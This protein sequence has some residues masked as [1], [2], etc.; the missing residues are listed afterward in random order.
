MGQASYPL[1]RGRQIWVAAVLL[2][3]VFV[4]SL[5]GAKLSA[6]FGRHWR[7]AR[8]GTVND[9]APT[10]KNPDLLIGYNLDYPGDWSDALPFLDL[11]HDARLWE[12]GGG[13]AGPLGKYAA[14]DLDE[15][16]WPRS[17]GGYA[18]LTAIVRTG[19]S[20]DF[21]GKVWVLS[22]KGE[23]SLSIQGGIDVLDRRPGRIRFRGEP[24]NVW[25]SIEADDPHKVG[26]YL[27]DI[28]IVR[29]DRQD[30]L[31]AGKLFN[32]DLLSFLAPYR[33][34]RFMDWMLS[35]DEEDDH[36][37]RWPER[38]KPVQVQWRQQ[39]IDPRRP[40]AG[41]TSPGYPVEI[42]IALANQLRAHPHFNLPYKFDDVYARSFATLVKGTLLPGLVAT[43]EYSN[44]LWNWGFPQATYARLEAAKLWPGEGTGWLQFMGARAST[45]CRIWKEVFGAEKQRLRCLIAPQTGWTDV[46]SA[47]LDCPRWVAMGHEPCY[48]SADAIGITGYFNGLLPKPENTPLI[49]QWLQQ[50]KASALDK[51]FRQLEWGDVENIK[52]GDGASTPERANSLVTTLS[53]FR[54]FR[55]IADE[56]GLGLYVYEGGTH[57]DHGPDP[58]LK[59]FLIDV[60]RDPRMTALYVKMFSGFASV[61][62]SVFNVWGGIGRASAWANADHLMDRSHPKYRAAV[63]FQASQRRSRESLS[64]PK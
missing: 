62:G 20:P 24:G 64:R 34:L 15:H 2:C 39:F 49:K 35:N 46:A 22:Y 36:A 10:P 27:R 7:L 61:N 42:M 45:M 23:G 48:K 14:L 28:T 11:M 21:V 9:S 52:D 3:L 8:A 41:L 56:R 4:L 63:E 19:D 44:E 32:P 54:T 53:L 29:E 25:I 5:G 50:G 30:L 33:S 26:H 47:S 38:T 51:A 58:L 18:W 43:V 57:F 16:G 1:A 13:E 6:R 40:A 37:G 60:G 59:Q 17:L 55:R 31:A 12:G